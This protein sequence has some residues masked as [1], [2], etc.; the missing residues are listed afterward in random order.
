MSSVTSVYAQKPNR[1]SYLLATANSS[2]VQAHT[3]AAAVTLLPSFAIP[4]SVVPYGEFNNTGPAAIVDAVVS[5]T[6]GQ[7]FR[8]LGR[9]IVL[10]QFPLL[11]GVQGSPHRAVF[12]ECALMNGADIEGLGDAT[13]IWVKV[14][15][16]DSYNVVVAR[17]G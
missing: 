2:A 4:N 1:A 15:S 10:Y 5:I 8:D 6:K 14:S 13:N 7:L 9:E 17:V 11:G 12:R 16:D 3:D